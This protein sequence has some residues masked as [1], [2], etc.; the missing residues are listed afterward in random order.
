MTNIADRIRQSIADKQDLQT[1]IAAAAKLA[2]TKID[3]LELFRPTK[4]QEDVVLSGASEILVQ[5]A[6]RSV[7]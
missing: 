6:P 5:G 1:G 3:A 7:K 4:Y 2:K